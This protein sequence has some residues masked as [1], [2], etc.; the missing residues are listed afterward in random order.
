MYECL[1]NT[2]VLV[3]VNVK[4]ILWYCKFAIASAQV[5]N[6]NKNASIVFY[7]VSNKIQVELSR[8]AE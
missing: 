2:L 4:G 5:M 7:G 1:R 3:Q 6:F 8:N